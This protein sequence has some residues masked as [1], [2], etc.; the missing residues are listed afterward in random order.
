MEQTIKIFA[1]LFFPAYMLV[2][3]IWPSIRTYRSTGINP[4][5]FG[6]SDNATDYVGKLFKVN[7]ALLPFAIIFLWFGNA[8]YEILM[9][10]EYMHNSAVQIAGM[11]ICTLSFIC[12]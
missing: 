2:A 6:E 3:F 11:V 5:V 7:I 10:V 9:P 1:S 4:F 8:A 12:A